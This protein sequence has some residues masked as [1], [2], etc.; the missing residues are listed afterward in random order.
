MAAQPFAFN[1]NPD[2]PLRLLSLDGGGVR[3]LSSLLVLKRLMESIAKEEQRLKKR[4]LKDNTPLKPCDYF[5]LIGGTSTGGI[6]AILLGRLR[7]D[8]PSC[9]KIYTHLSQEIFRRDKSISLFGTK[10]SLGSTRFSGAVLEAAIK[11]ALKDLGF[12]EDEL[13]WDGTAFEQVI[14]EADPG[15]TIWI[16]DQGPNAFTDSPFNDSSSV[17]RLVSNGAHYGG[18]EDT[19][20]QSQHNSASQSS[21]AFRVRRS[22]SVRKRPDARGCPTFVV[23]AL[24]NALGVPRLFVTYDPNDRQTR[25]W[26]ALRATSAAPTFFE[27]MTFGTPRLTYL[28]GGLGFNNP[29]IEVNYTA[30][31]LWEGR[32]IG[33]VVSIGTGLQNIPSIRKASSWNPFGQEISLATALA[34]MATSTARVDNEMQRLYWNTDTRY[35]RFDVDSGMSDISLEEFMK[36]NEMGSATEQYMHEPQ[37]LLRSNALAEIL[38]SLSALPPKIEIPSRDFRVGVDGRGLIHRD[39]KFP[40]IL[41][42]QQED[43]DLKSGFPLGLKVSP[44]DVSRID[45]LRHSS[46]SGKGGVNVDSTGTVRKI[47][48]VAEDLDGDGKREEATVL[49]CVRADN[50]CLRAMKRGVPRGRYAVRFI[51][52]LFEAHPGVNNETNTLA[53]RSFPPTPMQFAAGVFDNEEVSHLVVSQDGGTVDDAMKPMVTAPFDLIFSAGKPYD[54]K[55]FLHRYVDVRITPDIVPVLLHPDAVRVRVGHRRCAE[56]KGKGWFEVEGDIEV[57]V[58]LDGV[59]GIIINKRFEEGVFV[60]GWSFGGVR[61]IPNFGEQQGRKT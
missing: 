5:D 3:G 45:E 20:K 61:L 39:S 32:P 58:G 21:S 33:V 17:S 13:M 22:T 30:K 48:P 10:F 25:I 7:Q 31:S 41:C 2:A 57:E 59:L 55:S 40:D 6:I 60:G 44:E 28:D 14:E 18:D 26:E 36:E 37:Q 15:E 49:T 50:I 54:F 4:S 46:P 19:Q 12:D 24:K 53:V 35:F 52:C 47:Y 42:F 16:Q 23:S 11:R 27:E 9:I 43:L 29:C 34:S 56:R 51:I 38:V 8:V 1:P